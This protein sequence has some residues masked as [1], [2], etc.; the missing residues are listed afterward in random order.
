MKVKILIFCVLP[1]LLIG[2]VSTG[3]GQEKVGTTSFQFLKVNPDARA[4]AMGEAGVAIGNN[5]SALFSN[6][7]GIA[8]IKGFDAGISYIDWFM[9]S[10]ISAFTAAYNMSYLGSIGLMGIYTSVGDIEVTRVDR[11]GFVGETYNPGLTG[12]TIS[13]YFFALG[14]AYGRSITDKFSFGIT[15]K[16]VTE[17]L[18]LEKTANMLF[19]G[20]LIYD[21]GFR[22]LKLAAVVRHFGPDI[23][24]VEKAFPPPQTFD[25]G[26][27]AYILGPN[28][29]MVVNSE[30]QKLLVSFDL[31]HPRDYAQQYNAGIEYSFNDLIFLRGGYKINY[32]EEGLTLGF[33]INLKRLIIDYSYNDYGDFISSVHRFTIRFSGID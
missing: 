26:I 17:D 32:D 11:L 13:P 12:E 21:T 16:Y 23:K 14:V 33:G 6:P 7:A 22:T 10:Y 27:S 2:L 31:T 28:N 20:G 29:P 19:D 5:S 15:A 1:I 3:F 24:F 4:T 9:D 8:H 30:N 25:I 18:G